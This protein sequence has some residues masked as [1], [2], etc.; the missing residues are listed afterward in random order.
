[1]TQIPLAHSGAA[2]RPGKRVDSKLRYRQ[3]IIE[4]TLDTIAEHGISGTTISRIVE[5]A[6]VAR[7][8]VNL[9]FG[10]KEVLLME[11]LRDLNQRYADHFTAVFADRSSSRVQRLMNYVD[12]ELDP[13]IFNVRNTS[14]WFAFRGERKSDPDYMP[15]I[16]SR[17]PETLHLLAELFADGAGK[18]DAE[19]AENLAEGLM[20][21][22]EGIYSDFHL[23]PGQ[24]DRTKARA[25]CAAFIHAALG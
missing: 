12:A 9:H 6:G 18:A 13:A 24:F 10:T 17:D 3:A 7:G 15:L 21:L 20:L 1:M 5:R 2:D 11:A 16:E 4:A 23:H 8:M 19:R 22:M 14:V 25:I